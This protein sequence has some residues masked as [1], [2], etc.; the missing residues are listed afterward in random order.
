M[1]GIKD[2]TDEELQKEYRQLFNAV[3]NADCFGI[4]DLGR[5]RV[6]EQ[7]LVDRGYDIVEH[8][9]IDFVKEDPDDVETDEDAVVGN[10]AACG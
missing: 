2:R 9:V 7:K 3:V 6:L 4:S 5:L 8:A 1:S 10:A